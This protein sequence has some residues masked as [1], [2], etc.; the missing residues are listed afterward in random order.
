MSRERSK[1]ILIVAHNFPPLASGGVHRPVKFARYLRELG[2][3]V[4][5]LTVK[6]IRYHAYDPSLL[7][8]LE[9]VA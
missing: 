4:D 7:D 2:W 5:V 8:E 9:G 6:D 3:E 1:R